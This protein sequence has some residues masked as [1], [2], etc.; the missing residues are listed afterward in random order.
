MPGVC[1]PT[2]SFNL[3]SE[4]AVPPI[5]SPTGCSSDETRLFPLPM[6]PATSTFLRH[7]SVARIKPCAVP[8]L[9]MITS[10][11]AAPARKLT[12]SIRLSAYPAPSSCLEKEIF[13]CGLQLGNGSVGDSVSLAQR[14]PQLVHRNSLPPCQYAPFIAIRARRSDVAKVSVLLVSELG[15]SFERPEWKVGRNL[16]ES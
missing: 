4:F 6:R 16:M 10:A 7:T 14:S 3:P 15:S 8:V 1:P 5:H 13:L 9:P 11:R 2:V 12:R